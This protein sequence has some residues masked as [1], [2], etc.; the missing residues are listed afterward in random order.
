MIDSDGPTTEAMMFMAALADETYPDA[1]CV[2]RGQ[3]AREHLPVVLDY[4]RR[5]HAAL[6]HLIS[7]TEEHPSGCFDALLEFE[8]QFSATR[9]LTNVLGG[10]LNE[11]TFGK[12]H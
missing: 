6:G 8:A 12:V 1:E 9:T 4:M 10:A 7:E 11:G 5:V 2:A 3:F